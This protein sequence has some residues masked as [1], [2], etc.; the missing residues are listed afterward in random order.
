V[1]LRCC[2]RRRSRCCFRSRWSLRCH[3]R[4]RLHTVFYDLF[5]DLVNTSELTDDNDAN[6]RTKSTNSHFI[7][8]RLAARFIETQA[9]TDRNVFKRRSHIHKLLTCFEQKSRQTH[10]ASSDYSNRDN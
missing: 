5:H 8:R 2:L 1:F 3:L 7:Q 4:W 9:Q 10:E 6:E